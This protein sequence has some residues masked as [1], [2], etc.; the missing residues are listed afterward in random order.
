MQW[1]ASPDNDHPETASAWS[2]VIG[3]KIGYREGEKVNIKFVPAAMIN[4]GLAQRVGH[5][6]HPYRDHPR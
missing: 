4:V 1:H 3:K 5:V 6:A 2:D